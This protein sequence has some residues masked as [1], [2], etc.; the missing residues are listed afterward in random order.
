M[1]VGIITYDKGNSF[2][3]CLYSL[4]RDGFDP[5]VVCTHPFNDIPDRAKNLRIIHLPENPGY[6]KAINAILSEIHDHCLIVNDD[7]MI[8][9]DQI[10][11]LEEELE[12]TKHPCILQPKLDFGNGEIENYGHDL[13]IDAFNSARFRGWESSS[14]PRSN[15]TV[16]S[17][18]AFVIHRDVIKEVGLFSEDLIFY[19]EEVDYTLR[20]FQKNIYVKGSEATFIHGYGESLGE[21]YN[22]KIYL[23]ERNRQ[24]ILQRLY[25]RSCSYNSIVG[26]LFRKKQFPSVDSSKMLPAL[27]GI[28]SGMRY[29]YKRQISHKNHVHSTNYLSHQNNRLTYSQLW[30]LFQK[31]N[32]L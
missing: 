8:P 25:P 19:G 21:V 2:F 6:G 3:N 5:I 22:E 32:R 11:I 9:K 31:Q 4:Q 10:S 24:K 20:M 17:G 18:A 23:I 7:I 26:A 27:L 30:A 13:W 14:I 12:R 1:E 15:P 28:L 16:F 29:G